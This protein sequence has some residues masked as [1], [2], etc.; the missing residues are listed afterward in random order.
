MSRKASSHRFALRREAAEDQHYF[1]GDC[2]DDA[3][4][5]LI[6]EEQVNELRELDVIDGDLG[7]IRRGNH[8]VALFCPSSFRSH[9]EIP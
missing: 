9:E 1:R 7:L 6:V 2:V 4:D 8:E 5:L 3:A